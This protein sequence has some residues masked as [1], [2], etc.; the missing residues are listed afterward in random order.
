MAIR[1]PVSSPS[2]IRVPGVAGRLPG[3]I[4]LPAKDAEALAFGLHQLGLYGVGREGVLFAQLRQKLAGVKEVLVCKLKDCDRQLLMMY[5]ADQMTFV[6][7]G[8]V[9][10]LSDRILVMRAGEITGE[11]TRREA[12]QDA[13]MHCAAGGTVG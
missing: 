2:G 12:T 5:Y 9:L 4:G 6:Q 13:I 3:P 8:E 1:G 7:I 11:F 10:G